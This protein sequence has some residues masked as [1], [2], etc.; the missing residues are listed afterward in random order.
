M[1]AIH[2]DSP[3]SQ[4][5]RNLAAML[6]DGR[7]QPGA[8]L[9]TVA[10]FSDRFAVARGTV[11]AALAELEAEG[12]IDNRGHRGRFAPARSARA[13]SRTALLLADNE[14]AADVPIDPGWDLWL[15]RGIGS[16]LQRRGLFQL[17]A[18]ADAL[19][20]TALAR[21]NADPPLGVLARLDVAA[22]PAGI[23]VLD[24]FIARR[25]PVV[26]NHSDPRWLAADR[27]LTDF[28][29]G[30]RMLVE[31][32]AARGRR[33]ILRLWPADLAETPFWLRE[34]DGGFVAATRDLGLPCLPVRH[35]PVLPRHPDTALQYDQRVRALAGALVDL[36]LSAEPP[37][38]LMCVSDADATLAISACRLFNREPG[39]DVLIT[40]YDAFWRTCPER[41]HESVLLDATIDKR[42]DD[43]GEAMVAAL[44][45]RAGG[46]RS[47]T[48]LRLIPPRLILP[49]G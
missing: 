19:D 43:I 17:K 40:G 9:P 48:E 11:L 37:D 10:R 49:R 32:L 21:L 34:R 13:P 42:H 33:R 1:P 5:R 16:A 28:A 30:T 24:G 20:D 18:H 6:C 22:S 8:R 45:E 31:H 26:V 41:T 12:L 27:V 15:D 3:R 35:H 36:F 44:M 25:V 47:E 39:R 23:R 46:Q 2:H 29:L 38:A 4:V 7:L 14:L